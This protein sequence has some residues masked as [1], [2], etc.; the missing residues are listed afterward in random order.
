MPKRLKWPVRDLSL[1]L[2][3]VRPPF[4]FRRPSASARRGGGAEDLWLLLTTAILYSSVT[5]WS[6]FFINK[7]RRARN[8][9][10]KI[11]MIIPTNGQAS[12]ISLFFWI[13][14]LNPIEV[15]TCGWQ[16]LSTVYRI[17]FAPIEHHRKHLRIVQ[18]RTSELTLHNLENVM[19]IL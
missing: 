10:F 11:K 15:R 5:F 18:F 7:C 8:F 6:K 2:F 4:I 13:K 14:N 17:S 1:P 9:T 3:F 19:G 12:I 16:F